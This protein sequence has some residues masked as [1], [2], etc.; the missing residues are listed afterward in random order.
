ME[1]EL[2]LYEFMASLV[3]ITT[4]WSSHGYNETLCKRKSKSWVAV[5][6]PRRKPLLT[7]WLC[8]IPDLH[9][10]TPELDLFLKNF[11]FLLNSVTKVWPDIMAMSYCRMEIY[12][13][14]LV[15]PLSTYHAI[16]QILNMLW[17][18][19]IRQLSKSQQ[20]M[21]QIN[22]TSLKFPFFMPLG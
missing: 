19:W 18:L 9:I 6:Q 20:R 17:V 8:F 5:W 13:F 4:Y 21:L 11:C 12:L 2:A 22:F 16:L 14:L 7:T 15:C 10:E 1:A 3:C